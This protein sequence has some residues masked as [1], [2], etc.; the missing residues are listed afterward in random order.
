MVHSCMRTPEHPEYFKQLVSGFPVISL[1][2]DKL[3]LF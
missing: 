3:H 2:D 1:T